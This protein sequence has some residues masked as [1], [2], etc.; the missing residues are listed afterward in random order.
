MRFV[1]CKR[2]LLPFIHNAIIENHIEGHIFCDLFAG[3]ATVGQYFKQQGFKIISNDFLYTSYIMQKVKVEIN[4]MPSFE[5][6]ANHLNLKKNTK[7]HYAQAAI[8]YLNELKGSEG[9]I[10]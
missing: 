6:L 3:T 4:I 8:D 10:Y 1:G 5:K 7:E 9:F 2:R